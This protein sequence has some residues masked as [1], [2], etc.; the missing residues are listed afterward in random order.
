[1]FRAGVLADRKNPG[2]DTVCVRARRKN[3]FFYFHAREV[4][5]H[6]R[7]GESLVDPLSESCESG[8]GSVDIAENCQAGQREIKE[9]E[10]K[11]APT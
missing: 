8:R 7:I 3:L 10:N 9:N 4:F 11:S 1:M 6:K 5:P 2:A